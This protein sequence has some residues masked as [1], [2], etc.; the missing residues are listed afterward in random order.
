MKVNFSQRSEERMKILRAVYDE[1]GTQ[2][3]I[4]TVGVD[5]GFVLS[6]AQPQNSSMKCKMIT[7]N[8][9]KDLK[10]VTGNPDDLIEKG[11]IKYKKPAV[12]N[13]TDRNMR[14]E[15]AMV[16]MLAVRVVCRPRDEP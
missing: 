11:L 5:G 3:E 8:N 2:N 4:S 14:A 12:S 15:N 16:V 9:I 10:M 6:S 1:L 7:I 13:L